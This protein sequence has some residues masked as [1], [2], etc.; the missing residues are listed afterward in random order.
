MGGRSGWKHTGQS[1]KSSSML[2]SVVAAPFLRFAKEP[3]SPSSCS[4]APIPAIIRSLRQAATELGGAIQ[5][6]ADSRR[7]EA[8]VPSKAL[9][10]HEIARG[11]ERSC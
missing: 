2:T 3:Q 10:G 1:R 6:A 11:M 7:E 4:G 5:R 9:E 8:V